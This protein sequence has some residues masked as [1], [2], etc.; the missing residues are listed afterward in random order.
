MNEESTARAYSLKVPKELGEK[1]IRLAASLDLLDRS[2]KIRSDNSFL[3]VPLTQRP[4]P[5]HSMKLEEVLS[6]FDVL[7]QDFSMRTKPRR[8]AFE[9]VGDRLPPH[10][11]ASFPRSVDLVGDIAVVE[12]PPELEEH[13]ELVG[14]AILEAH[15]Q[16]RTV[17]AKSSAISGV[18]R[19]REFE[20]IAGSEKTE[21]VHKEHGCRYHLDLR[22][23][24][25]SPRLSF[26]HNR[27]ASQVEENETVIDMFAGVGPFSVLI[28]K[29]HTNVKVYA[30]DVNPDAVRYLERNIAVNGVVEKV[31]P[32]LGDAR[33]VI[34]ERLRGT[35]DRVIM[36]LPESASEYLDSACQAMKPEGGVIHYYEFAEG[37]NPLEPAKHRLVKALGRTNRK[38]E[39]FLSART[40][41]EV[42]PFKW[43]VALDTR[44][45]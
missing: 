41:R 42:A 44:I 1:A 22:K 27:V 26:E 5:T 38:A 39:A 8:A 2:L 24:Y 12:V 17:L 35:A 23:V 19:L 7:A 20:V 6:Q 33:D 25:F 30:V 15:R 45:R 3:Y 10:L 4:L 11:L 16:A 32:I 37:S 28:A 34:C 18:C 31:V 40:V 29:T 43:Q 13:K 14:E 21:T 36:N 9:A